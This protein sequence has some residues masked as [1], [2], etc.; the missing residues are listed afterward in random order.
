M[1]APSPRRHAPRRRVVGELLAGRA[2]AVARHRARRVAVGHVVRAERAD[3]AQHRSTRGSGRGSPASRR[4]PRGRGGGAPARARR[5]RRRSRTRRSSRRTPR[6]ASWPACTARH[7]SRPAPGFRGFS[8]HCA[9]RPTEL[10]PLTSIGTRS[11]KMPRISSVRSREIRSSALDPD[12]VDADVLALGDQRLEHAVD[13][14]A[15]HLAL[16]EDV[17]ADREVVERVDRALDRRRDAP[18]LRP[19][20]PR[21]RAG[22]AADRAR[23][24]GELAHE[25]R[26]QERLAARDREQLGPVVRPRTCRRSAGTSRAGASS[27]SQRRARR[28][29]RAAERTAA[30]QR[31]RH[32][33][34]GNGSQRQ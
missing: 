33:R 32:A 8:S 2:V 18:R 3:R 12:E 10:T 22:A 13:V 17:E 6:A 4:W 25:L 23:P 14:L 34:G 21:E 15:P 27:L 26:P 19:E 11:S 30:R 7:R 20:H 1:A 5:R 28:A 31:E 16:V 24:F 29:V 9:A